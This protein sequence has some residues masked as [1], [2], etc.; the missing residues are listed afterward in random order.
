LQ[1]VQAQDERV[2]QLQTRLATLVD[3][4]V[5]QASSDPMVPERL[6]TEA[7]SAVAPAAP[8]F[9]TSV[10]VPGLMTFKALPVSLDPS[11]SS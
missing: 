2:L 10:T 11:A 9:E 8:S 4:L 3:A 1:E 5:A 6:D 7:A